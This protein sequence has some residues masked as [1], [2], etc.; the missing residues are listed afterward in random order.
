MAHFI[1]SK[2][3]VLQSEIFFFIVSRQGH[4]VQSACTNMYCVWL[5]I[6]FTTCCMFNQCF[7][8]PPIHIKNG[9]LHQLSVSEESFVPITLLF[10]NQNRSFFVCT[11]VL[12][13]FLYFKESSFRWKYVW[14]KQWKFQNEIFISME[15]EAECILFVSQ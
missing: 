8:G 5:Q 1:C 10:I 11:S 12:W 9:W 15:F 3:V 4:G 2:G 6:I 7:A 13:K 14:N